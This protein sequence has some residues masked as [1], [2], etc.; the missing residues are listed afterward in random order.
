LFQFGYFYA[1]LG[2]LLQGMKRMNLPWLAM[3]SP[4]RWVLRKEELNPKPEEA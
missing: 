2:S 4:F 1:G 3:P